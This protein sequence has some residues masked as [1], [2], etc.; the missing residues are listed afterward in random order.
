[1]N[2]IKDV[3]FSVKMDENEK[4]ALHKPAIPKPAEI[5]APN[6]F[7]TMTKIWWKWHEFLPTSF[8]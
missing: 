6:L 2:A 5:T 3:K 1:M 4:V 7:E 8:S